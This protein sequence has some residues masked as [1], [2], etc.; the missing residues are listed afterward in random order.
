MIGRY[1]AGLLMPVH[2]SETGLPQVAL[3]PFWLLPY[4]L[5]ANHLPLLT[6]IRCSMLDL[7]GNYTELTIFKLYVGGTPDRGQIL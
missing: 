6:Y 7:M 3:M 1:K 2:L 4:P 5:N